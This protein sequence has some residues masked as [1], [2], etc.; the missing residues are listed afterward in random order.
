MG[1]VMIVD[2]D[3]DFAAATATVLTSEGHEIQIELTT[4]QALADMQERSPDLVIL[5]VMFPEDSA[6]GFKMAR[7]MRQE[8]I[9]LKRVP[10]LLL[11]AIN[12]RFAVGFGREDIDVEW[13]PV[14]DFLDK[15]VDFDTLIRRVSDLLAKTG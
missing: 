6:A 4:R 12:R 14:D 3:Q 1:Y 13:L 2:D 10:I 5:D 7:E 9:G 8:H 15:P 11:S